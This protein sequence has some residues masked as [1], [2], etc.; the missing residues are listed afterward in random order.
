[1]NSTAT[2]FLIYA[3]FTLISSG[4]LY[5]SFKSKIDSSAAYFLTSEMCMLMTCTILF[6]IN[7]NLIKA[8]S[9]WTGASNFGALGAEFAIIFSLLS[10]SNKIEKRWFL[11]TLISLA[12]TVIFLE[13]IRDDVD[14]KLII[15]IQSILTL[16][17]SSFNYFICKT[18][19]KQNLGNNQFVKWFTLFA[20]GIVIYALLRLLG[21]FAP[22][23][24]IP[25]G[26]PSNLMLFVLC[27]YVVM[28]SFR[29]F[30]Y[31]GLRS[32][33]VDPVNPSK[34]NLNKSLAKE[35]EEKNQ[36]L[37]DLIRS[38]R[39]IGIST[40][41]SSIAHQISQP[42]STIALRADITRRD[43]IKSKR[44]AHLISSLDEVATQSTKLADLV[45]SLRKLFERQ[46]YKFTSINLLKITE[47]II[48]IV[49]QSLEGKQIRLHKDFLSNPQVLGDAIQ[50]QQILINVFNNAIDALSSSDSEDKVIFIRIT[51]DNKFAVIEIEDNGVG[52]DQSYLSNI[53]ELYR[54]TKQDGLGVGLWLCKAIVE[55]HR[56]SI[57]AFSSNNGGTIFRIELP[58]F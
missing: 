51:N 38:N 47:E 27:F 54:T 11:I 49:E 10:L 46:S 5:S 17:A 12:S 6:L 48:E 2:L 25:R 28:G 16:T 33:W 50:I 23:P 24:V 30:S 36:L 57:N 22:A 42:L 41:A 32:T 45:R 13:S 1:M 19:L 29:Y 56:G 4:I 40:L 18:Q 3:I 39:A 53:F 31:I 15:L 14:L 55:R 58:L 20:L 9:I 43:L 35:I 7:I 21:Y 37:Q 52:I 44:D 34:N 26:E 8:T